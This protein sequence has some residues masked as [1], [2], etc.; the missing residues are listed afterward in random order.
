LAFGTFSATHIAGA[1]GEI[2]FTGLVRLYNF[3][4]LSTTACAK[5]TGSF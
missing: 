3:W 5:K 4:N 2:L 1:F